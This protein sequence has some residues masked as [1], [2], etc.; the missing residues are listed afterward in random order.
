MCCF[1]CSITSYKMITMYLLSDRRL[2]RNINND[3]YCLWC[4]NVIT[5]N[6]VVLALCVACSKI[7]G[8]QSCR[9]ITCIKQP[10]PYCNE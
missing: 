1:D 10:C 7:V 3:P 9:N 4:H 8:H 6:K 2:I 5:S